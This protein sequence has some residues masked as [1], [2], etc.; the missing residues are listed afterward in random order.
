[1]FPQYGIY[2]NQQVV[3]VNGENGARMYQLPPSSS[4]LLLDET[5]PRVFL[6]QT[7]GAGYKTI[8]PYKIEPI[9]PAPQPDLLDIMDRLTKLEA[10][11]EQSCAR[12]DSQ[13]ERNQQNS[14]KSKRGLQRDDE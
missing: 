1:M 11:Y 14:A 6:I 7:D 2:N 3:K 8:N 9:V 13:T 10:N 12:Y 4:A 5:S